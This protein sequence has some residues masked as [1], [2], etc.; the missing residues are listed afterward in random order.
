MV[1]IMG[2]SGCGKTTLLNI[3]SGIDEPTAGMVNVNGQPLYG[4]SDDQRTDLRGSQFGFIFQDFNLL[5]VLSAVENVELP[6]LLQGVAANEAR[7]TAMEA[8][9]R[10]GLG[11]RF[12]H[13]PAELSGG[14]QQRVAVARAIVHSPSIILCDE[15]TGNLDT[16]TSGEV[17]TLLR[18]MNQDE[19]T[20]FLIV[21]HDETIAEACQRTIT[22]QDGVVVHA[23]GTIDGEEE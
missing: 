8:L 7:T 18:A 23:S 11:D 3:L 19:G 14:Q 4:I 17:M 15:P 10:V 9:T 22:M 2:P 21:T 16:A 12:E 6:L 13:R 20:T 1:A 5:P